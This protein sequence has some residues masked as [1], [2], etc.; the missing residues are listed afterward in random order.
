MSRR[1]RFVTIALALLA[2]A[3]VGAAVVDSLGKS[4][5]EKQAHV[6]AREVLQTHD[7]QLSDRE[8]LAG[9][10]RADSV[11]GVLYFVDPDCRLHALRL[12]SLAAAPAPRDGG[13]RAL[14]SPASAP[15]GWSLWPRNTPLAVR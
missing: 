3:V 15:P 8:A 7:V 1:P 14:V 12:P 9:Q 10:L 5:F 2:I 4:V 11:S 13:C 6:K